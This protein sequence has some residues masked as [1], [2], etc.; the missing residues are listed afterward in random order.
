MAKIVN[1]RERIWQIQEVVGSGDAGEVLRVHSMQ[2]GFEG[3]MKRPVQNVSGGTILRQAA[4]IETEGKILLALEGLNLFR[5]G[6]TIHTPTLFDQSIPGTSNTAN[7][8]IVSEE[9]SGTPITNLLQAKHSGGEPIP[10]NVVMKVLSAAFYLL[11]QIHSKGIIWNDVKME[12]IYWD[13]NSRKMSFIDWGNGQF[14]TPQADLATSP[15]WQD[16]EQLIEEGSALLNQTAPHLLLDLGWPAHSKDLDLLQIKQLQMRVN[17]LEAYL[18]MR[19]TE[20]QLLFQK[21]TQSLADFDSLEQTLELYKDL[22]AFGIQTNN[23]T[24]LKA[25]QELL[26]KFLENEEYDSSKRILAAMKA[27]VTDLL[28]PQWHIVDYLIEADLAIPTDK[29]LE[30][31]KAIF[32][33]EWSE[34]VWLARNLISSDERRSALASLIY[35]TRNLA[36][37]SSNTPTIYAEMLALKNSLTEQLRLLKQERPEESQFAE[38][39]AQ[40]EKALQELT[41]AWAVLKKVEALGEKFITLKQILGAVNSLQL[42]VPRPLTELLQQALSSIREVYQAWNAADFP[43]IFKAI[44]KLYLTEPTLDYLLPFM[45]QLESMSSR[46]ESFETGPQAEQSITSF[47][48]SL[49]EQQDDLVTHLTSAN[50]LNNYLYALQSMAQALDLDNLRDLAATYEW[51]TKWLFFPNLHLEIPFEQYTKSNLTEPQ[52][53]ALQKYHSDLRLAK[54]TAAALQTIKSLLPAFYSSYKQLDEE[55]NFVFSSIPREPF[56]PVLSSFP[57]QDEQTIQKALDVLAAINKWKQTSEA[58]D[59]Y[60]QELLVNEYDDSWACLKNIRITTRDWNQEILPALVDIKQRKWTSGRSKQLP[61]PKY[62][63]L[64]ETLAHLYSF[65]CE[66]Q[67]IEYQGLYPELLKE[68]AYHMD[69]AQNTFFDFWQS[70][71]RSQSSSLVWL[72]QNQQSVFSEINQT[73]LSL[74]RSIKSL[75]RNYEVINQSEMAR[76]RLAQNS[77]GDL[78]FTLTKVDETVNPAQ[79]NSSVFKRWQRQYLDLL[80]KPDRATIREGIR[81]IELIHPLLPWFDEL[82]Q[83]D[84]GYFEQPDP[85]QW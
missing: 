79:K 56:S 73:L 28:T 40:I 41:G 8:F 70:L 6:L 78:M 47:A 67:K 2:G 75:Q 62:P 25:S 49:L 54:S 80:S 83:R 43:S 24:L 63:K 66:W 12:H 16:Y 21:F 61:H 38:G 34:V 52:I 64:L 13:A 71:Q 48:K 59:W 50:W 33:S 74:L 51:P 35:T 69:L 65:V 10:L 60:L 39:L 45:G 58:G 42:K 82:V 31:I 30:L 44:K 4:Q 23:Q 57:P 36:F 14:I 26:L 72:I 37:D 84:A 46:L 53:Q 32:S 29:L 20:Y 19:S 22:K 11:E 5:D 17:Y 1:G 27:Q 85:H 18:T 76:T 3:V 15:I 68:L 77:A 55:F 81:E 7:L 9:V